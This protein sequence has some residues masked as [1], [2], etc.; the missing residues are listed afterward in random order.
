MRMASSRLKI[1]EWPA[2]L[3]EHTNAGSEYLHHHLREIELVYSTSSPFAFIDIAPYT[4]PRNAVS[5]TAM[6]IFPI[7]IITLNAHLAT[8]IGASVCFCQGDRRSL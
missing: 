1:R 5:I 7:V 8:A 2:P 6:S 3:F 4:Q